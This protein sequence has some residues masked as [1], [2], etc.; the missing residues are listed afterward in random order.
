MRSMTLHLV[1]CSRFFCWTGVR[2]VSTSSKRQRPRSARCRRSPRPAP[3]RTGWPGGPGAGGSSCAR[4]RRCRSPRP[5]PP[6]RRAAP[7]CERSAPS[8][9]RSGTTSSARSPRAM[10]LS[11]LRLKT[12]NDRRFR[13]CRGRAAR[14]AASSKWRAC[15][16][17]GPARRARAAARTGRAPTTAPWSITPLTRNTVIGSCGALGGFEEQVLQRRA[18]GARRLRRRR[19]E[20]RHRRAA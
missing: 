7:R 17:V 11:S 13:R 2:T 9:L 12:L 1:I 8:P 16:P 3:C 4:R 19:V 14:P 18:L 20:R 5:G 10:P 15:R 6:P